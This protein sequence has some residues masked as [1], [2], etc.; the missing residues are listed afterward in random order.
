[1]ATRTSSQRSSHT[2]NEVRLRGRLAAEPECRELPSGDEV[3]TFRLIVDRRG[4]RSAQAAVDTIDCTVW[5]ASLRR[6]SASWAAGDL[7][8]VEGSLRRRF[9]RSPHGPRSRYDVE[10]TRVSRDRRGADS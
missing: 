3:V 5:A 2:V 10:V 8:I 7:L 9:W 4:A 6:R 1:M